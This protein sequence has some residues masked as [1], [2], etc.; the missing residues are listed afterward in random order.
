MI[1]KE[2]ITEY[3]VSVIDNKYNI[4]YYSTIR[5]MM[6][7][8]FNSYIQK[9]IK[10]NG[11]VYLS[12]KNNFRIFDMMFDDRQSKYIDVMN[13]SFKELY[14]IRLKGILFD[15]NNKSYFFKYDR[16]IVEED[17]CIYDSTILQD[18]RKSIIVPIEYPEN[19]SEYHK[20]KIDYEISKSTITLIGNTD[21]DD[22]IK[23]I[24]YYCEL[25]VLSGVT[26]RTSI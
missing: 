1:K 16:H 25:V 8:N 11:G 20:F 18:E 2:L 3:F 15:Y 23:N 21:I 22:D 17:G 6:F 19:A 24:K 10:D 4:V 9:A 26:W 13:Q 7:S 14:A 5:D 12:D